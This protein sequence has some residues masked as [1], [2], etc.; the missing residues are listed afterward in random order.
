MKKIESQ[1][2]LLEDI[3][4]V[5]DIHSEK[6][7]VV[8]HTDVFQEGLIVEKVSEN[9]SVLYLTNHKYDKKSDVTDGSIQIVFF[10]ISEKE[11]NKRFKLLANNIE[12]GEEVCGMKNEKI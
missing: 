5:E 9:C 6:Y 1:K 8:V 10:P 4:A 7:R 2:Q 11:L 12:K 3:F